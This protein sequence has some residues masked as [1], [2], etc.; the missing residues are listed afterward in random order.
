MM[1]FVLDCSIAISW[2]FVDENNKFGAFVTV[3]LLDEIW[4]LCSLTLTGN[5]KKTKTQTLAPAEVGKLTFNR[6]NIASRACIAKVSFNGCSAIA[7]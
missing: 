4:K 1:Q 2:Y 5:A 3:Y 6:L 7:C